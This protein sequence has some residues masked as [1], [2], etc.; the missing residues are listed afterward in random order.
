MKRW[1]IHACPLD[2]DCRA[3]GAPWRFHLGTPWFHF[4]VA[5]RPGDQFAGRVNERPRWVLF[6]RRRN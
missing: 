5:L 1:S 2:K 4:A 3:I 6:E